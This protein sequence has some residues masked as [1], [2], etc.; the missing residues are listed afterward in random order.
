MAEG[1]EITIRNVLLECLEREKL[2][3]KRVSKKPDTLEPA[4][5]WSEEWNEQRRKCEILQRLIQALESESV[6]AALAKWLIEKQIT[7]AMRFT[8]ETKA[9][10][11]C[12]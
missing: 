4:P 8:E 12:K 11:G 10:T 7:E 1:K 6:R 9:S 5:G 2:N 3:W